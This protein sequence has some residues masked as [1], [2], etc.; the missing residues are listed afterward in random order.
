M[1]KIQT[2]FYNRVISIGD[3]HGCIT[4]LKTLIEKISPTD[5][6]LLIFLGDYIDRGEDSKAT[7]EYL[8]ELSSKFK[9]AFIRGNHDSMFL[10]FLGLGGSMG[11]FFPV[12]GGKKTL[13]DYG[14]K[15]IEISWAKRGDR[16]AI[17]EKIPPSHIEFF[18]KTILYV[19]T[20][21][22]FYSH[23]GFDPWSDEPYNKQSESQYTW[24]RERFL[25]FTH[26][27]KLN[28]YV[29][30]GHTPNHYGYAVCDEQERKV[31]LDSCCYETGILSALV[32]EKDKK[33]YS[34]I[35]QSKNP[36]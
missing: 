31:N 25:N 28:K 21:D 34:N 12:N 33:N 11:E 23:A 26:L 7:I 6:D 22:E 13:H 3:I 5:K 19:E 29:I 17:F 10:S 24:T 18:N 2:D 1:I 32:L 16:R 20:E 9:C 14:L 36:L 8:L 35:I 30:H 15:D 27:T 4:E